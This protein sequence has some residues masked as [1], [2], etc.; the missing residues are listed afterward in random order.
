MMEIYYSK[1]KHTAIITTNRT[2]SSILEIIS[3]TYP[4]TLKILNQ[5]TGYVRWKESITKLKELQESGASIYIT[6]KDPTAR[7]H[8]GIGML[9]G[10]HV[11]YYDDISVTLCC[12]YL[13]GFIQGQLNW[14]NCALLNYNVF[15]SHVEWGNSVLWHLLNVNGI[16]ATPTLL[17]KEIGTK[18]Q[19]ITGPGVSHSMK[20]HYLE[21]YT[22]VLLKLLEDHTEGKDLILDGI[23]VASSEVR[24]KASELYATYCST[25]R[26]MDQVNRAQSVILT[27]DDYIGIEERCHLAMMKKCHNIDDHETSQD[28]I[29]EIASKYIGHPDMHWIAKRYPAYPGHSVT[30]RLDKFRH[31]V[32]NDFS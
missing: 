2:G 6:I 14:S 1:T 27:F 4:D 21:T 32:Y 15:D 12:S 8:S 9:F 19:Y 11:N 30:E 3:T 25:F 24:A 26:K 31:E 10:H 16:Y 18:P 23:G 5:S 17:D 29:D 28:L 7:R 13:T 22:S 20:Q